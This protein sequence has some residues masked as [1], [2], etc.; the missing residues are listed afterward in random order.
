MA[1]PSFFSAI[2]IAWLFGFIWEKHTGLSMTGSLFEVD[3]YGRGEYIVWKNL[4][5]PPLH[6]E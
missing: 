2:I 3:D 1:L 5:L 6:W 4:I